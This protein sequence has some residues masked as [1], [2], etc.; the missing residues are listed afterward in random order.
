MSIP[1]W[2][3]KIYF[4]HCVT[5]DL[6]FS[7]ILAI[8]NSNKP[9]V[10]QIRTVQGV[11]KMFSICL[12]ESKPLPDYSHTDTTQVDLRLKA[13]IIDGSFYLFI[14]KIQSERT[15]KLNV[16]DLLTLD[17]IRQGISLD[18]HEI[19]VEKLLREGL[20]KS[21]SSADKKYVLGDLYYEI[22]NKHAYI[23][24]YRAR[25]LQIIAGC[26]EKA[27]EVGSAGKVVD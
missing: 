21:Q 16:F 23:K 9:S 26:F 6:D 25:D 3:E 13:Q 22:A 4:K 10:I 14:T 19:S 27:N 7:S 2:K 20:I 8:T 5:H 12:T 18:L 1:I 11:D 24:N 17:K 15:D